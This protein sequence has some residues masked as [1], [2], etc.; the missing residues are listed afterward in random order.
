MSDEEF[1][2][3]Q[4]W[5]IGILMLPEKTIGTARQSRSTMNG[6]ISQHHKGGSTNKMSDHK[7][8][9]LLNSVYQLLNY[10]INEQLDRRTGKCIR[11]GAGWRQAGSKCKHQHT[12][13]ALHHT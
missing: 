5:V 9:V 4:A 8:V 11:T 6:T 3:V 7:P 13:N 12:K 2:I 1:L 10:I